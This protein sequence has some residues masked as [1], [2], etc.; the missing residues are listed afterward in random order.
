M[1]GVPGKNSVQLKTKRQ[2]GL[3]SVPMVWAVPAIFSAELF[4]KTKYHH[5]LATAVHRPQF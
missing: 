4:S 5:A 2:C 3:H 1:A